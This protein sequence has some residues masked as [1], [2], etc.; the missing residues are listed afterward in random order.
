[1]TYRLVS[2]NDN[3]NF[4]FCNILWFVLACIAFYVVYSGI[5]K[6][7]NVKIGTMNTDSYEHFSNHNTTRKLYEL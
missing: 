4:S 7:K 3:F 1:M 2:A 6:R 5:L